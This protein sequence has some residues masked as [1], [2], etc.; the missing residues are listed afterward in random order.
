MAKVTDYGLAQIS[1]KI[2]PVDE[3][4][5]QQRTVDYAGLE[6]ATD[7]PYGDVRSDIYFTGCV[8]FEM[9]TGHSP[10]AHSRNK[11]QRMARERFM[12]VQKLRLETIQG[13]GAAIVHRL[14][15]TMMELNPEKRYQTPAQLLEAIRQARA[16]ISGERVGSHTSNQSI[17]IIEKDDTLQDVL[18][19]KLKKLG[20]RVLIASDPARA[21]DRY[22]QSPFTVLLIDIGTTGVEG[23]GAVNFVLR[24]SRF[25]NMPCH[26][27]IIVSE[28]QQG[29]ESM[30]EDDLM[31]DVTILRR[32]LKMHE[33][34]SKLQEIAPLRTAV[35]A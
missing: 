6:R 27:L 22:E 11:Y 32:P 25:L 16:E 24:K 34:T 7:A 2:I 29:I 21:K 9:L 35:P 15:N 20:Y 17:F 1:S 18:R 5:Q 30:I 19:D 31:S 23:L 12:N 13:P 4:D 10:L 3:K 33:L 14:V 8:A 26:G 28:D